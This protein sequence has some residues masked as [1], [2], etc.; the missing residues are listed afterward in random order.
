[1]NQGF[2]LQ[3]SLSGPCCLYTICE[4]MWNMGTGLGAPWG[5]R[6]WQFKKWLEISL[7]WNT[8]LREH[9]LPWSNYLNVF[10]RLK[11]L[12]FSHEIRRFPGLHLWP[13]HCRGFGLLRGVGTWRKLL[14]LLQRSWRNGN[15]TWNLW[16]RKHFFVF[17][18]TCRFESCRSHCALSFYYV[19]L[20]R[21][22]V[23]TENSGIQIH[24][25]S[26]CRFL[27]LV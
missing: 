7:S 21:V 13:V 22:L 17:W 4:N 8:G 26:H 20:G 23:N 27:D 2:Y 3:T 16:F 24:V 19:A 18:G 1:M 9:Y 11:I 14:E 10:I 5:R 6:I 12:L 15:F 25:G